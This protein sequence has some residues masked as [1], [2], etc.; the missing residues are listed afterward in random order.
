MPEELLKSFFKDRSSKPCIFVS[1]VS[2]EG[3]ARPL[4]TKSTLRKPALRERRLG[5][6]ISSIGTIIRVL[7]HFRGNGVHPIT[8]GAA[9]RFCHPDN[10]S[11]RWGAGLC[12]TFCMLCDSAYRSQIAQESVP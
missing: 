9:E 1:D 7:W 3:V 6:W 4:D 10:G 11:I 2:E 12:A 5:L 8:L